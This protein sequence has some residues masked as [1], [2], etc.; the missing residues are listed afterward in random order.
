MNCTQT[1]LEL[2]GHQLSPSELRP[3][4]V[5]SRPFTD[6]PQTAHRALYQE[7]SKFLTQNCLRA[8]PPTHVL[9]GL[10]LSSSAFPPTFTILLRFITFSRTLWALYEHCDSTFNLFGQKLVLNSNLLCI[11]MD[12]Q[13]Y[14]QIW[15]GQKNWQW[16]KLIGSTRV[17]TRATWSR[18]RVTQSRTFGC[19]GFLLICNRNSSSQP[20]IILSL[21]L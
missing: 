20:I 16:W 17:Y 19:P 2:Y 4:A 18:E 15:D 3:S 6:R 21:N 11:G 10:M 14:C 7:C 5:S 9:Q 12:T 1:V 13:R 8:S